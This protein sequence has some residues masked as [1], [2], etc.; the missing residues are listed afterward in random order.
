MFDRNLGLFVA[1][2]PEAY[3]VQNLA[4]LWF[5]D[6]STYWNFGT[7]H[8]NTAIEKRKVCMQMLWC[9]VWL[10][11]YMSSHYHSSNVLLATI[12]TFRKKKQSEKFGKA[13]SSLEVEDGK[14]LSS[15]P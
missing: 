15:H 4:L 14:C 10:I 13:V 3:N 11:N 8:W 2:Q 12:Q 1:L 6:V 7:S 5:H 9:V